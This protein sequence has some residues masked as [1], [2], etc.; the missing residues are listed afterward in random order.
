MEKLKRGMKKQL[1]L[2]QKGLGKTIREAIEHL[3]ENGIKVNYSYAWKKWNEPQDEQ[4][5]TPTTETQEEKP[6]TNQEN[7]NNLGLNQMEVEETPVRLPTQLQPTKPEGNLL[8]QAVAKLEK[9]RGIKISEWLLERGVDTVYSPKGFQGRGPG[10]VFSD[11]GV[12]VIVT[13]DSLSDIQRSFEKSDN[14][15]FQS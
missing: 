4:T 2:E 3:K 8:N 1:L 13:K 15:P 5:Q 10:Y 7:K 9:G 11:A 6:E 14:P 12:D